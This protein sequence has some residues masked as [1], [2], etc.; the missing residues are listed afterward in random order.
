VPKSWSGISFVVENKLLYPF[1]NKA[2]TKTPWL[3]AITLPVSK[4]VII[5]KAEWIC[6]SFATGT[7]TVK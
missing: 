3:L 5:S 2:L 6:C 7:F 1:A 4:H